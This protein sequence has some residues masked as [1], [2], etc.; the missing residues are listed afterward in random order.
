MYMWKTLLNLS[1]SDLISSPNSMKVCFKI[2]QPSNK[3]WLQFTATYLEILY[4]KHN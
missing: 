2:R 4:T 3:S 1:Y